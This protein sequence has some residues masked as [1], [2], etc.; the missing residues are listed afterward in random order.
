MEKIL[1]VV[2]IIDTE[3]PT[4]GREDMIDSWDSLSLVVQ[5]LTGEL[6]ESLRDSFGNP[7]VI[8]WFMLDWT[9]YSKNDKEFQRRGH[10]ANLHAVWDFYRKGFLSDENLK[11]TKDGLYWHYH[12]PPLDGSWGWNKNWNDS[13]WYEY[14]LGKLILN[15]NYFPSVYRA[16]KYVETNENSHWLEDWIPFD[17]SSISPVKREFCDWSEATTSWSPYH[18]SVENYQIEGNMKRWIARSLPVAAKGG[19]GTLDPLEIEKAFDQVLKGEKAIFSFHTHDYYKSILEEF[20]TAHKLIERISKEKGVSFK[21]SNCLEALRDYENLELP[22]LEVQVQKKDHNI[23][24]VF[25]HVI[26]CKKPF[27]VSENEKGEIK[28]V[29]SQKVSDDNISYKAELP[30]DSVRFGVGANDVY[31]NTVVCNL[32]I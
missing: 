26:F 1:Y 28:I 27:I 10:D 12:H 21:Y 30:S 18:P 22:Q 7:L 15:H 6:R 2:P 19:S 32:N 11:K 29:N 24:I 16:G 4:L 9:G 13:K 5:K 8:N 25:N 14:I 23:D 20:S 3:G 31:G 17:Y